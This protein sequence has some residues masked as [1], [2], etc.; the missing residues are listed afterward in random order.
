MVY[1]MK[2]N[3]S[4]TFVDYIVLA[5]SEALGYLAAGVL[6][7]KLRTSRLI[8]VC[9]LASAALFGL[10]LIPLSDSPMATDVFVCLSSF[11]VSIAANA[12]F[13]TTFDSFH[14]VFLATVFGVMQL[15]GRVTAVGV[16]YIV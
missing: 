4:S 10:A 15:S 8:I 13:L 6:Y 3:L 5:N 9:A 14:T 2:S 11:A 7:H 1:P 12:T 16:P